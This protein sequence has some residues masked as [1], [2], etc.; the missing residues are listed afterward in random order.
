MNLIS[1]FL[2]SMGDFLEY[3]FLF[4]ALVG[5]LI[6]SITCGLI[7]PLIVARKFAFMGSAVSHSTLFGLSMGL[8][9]FPW[10]NTFAVFTTTLIITLLL[11]TFLAQATYRQKLPT[12]GLIGIFFTAS[13]GAGILL[14]HLFARQR[15]NLM[16]ILFGDILL[17]RV[18]DLWFSFFLLALFIPAILIP[19][20]KWIY[21]SYDEEGAIISGLNVKLFHYSFYFLVTILIVSSIKIAGTV[22]INTLLL[23]PGVFGLK[24]AK[25]IP[26]TFVYSVLFS[27]IF[28][29][30]G[31]LLANWQGLP[32]GATLSVIQFLALSLLLLL[33]KFKKKS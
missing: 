28:S 1:S 17:L 8:I 27:V 18:E 9:F 30:L 3:D 15:G 4:F 7:S 14:F 13:M 2:L 24:M 25:T 22:L 12:D 6:L 5:T 29:C 33:G 10:E 26:Q 20:K 16:G 19:F 23:V 11:V 32:S 31:L 21:T